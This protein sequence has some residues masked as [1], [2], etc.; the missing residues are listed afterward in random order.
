MQIRCVYI[1]CLCLLISLQ[2]Y[3]TPSRRTQKIFAKKKRNR[4][5]KSETSFGK[6]LTRCIQI[7]F[8]YFCNVFQWKFS[9]SSSPKNDFTKIVKADLNVSCPEL[10]GGGL[11]SV[12]ALSVCSTNIF[13]AGLLGG[14]PSFFNWFA[15]HKS[16][17]NRKMSSFCP[18]GKPIFRIWGNKHTTFQAKNYVEAK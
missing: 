7:C 8:D 16:H 17:Q 5:D 2:L 12:V 14:F 3:W 13:I 18:T 4:Y 1:S 11:G 10:S 6:L 9:V 15:K